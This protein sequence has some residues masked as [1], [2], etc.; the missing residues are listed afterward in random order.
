MQIVKNVLMAAATLAVSYGAHAQTA[1]EIVAK[2]V[3]AIGGKE[4]IKG[5]NSLVMQTSLEVM[6]NEASGTST[7]VPGKGFRTDAEIMGSKMVQVVTDKGGWAINPMA[8][9]KAEALPAEAYNAAKDQLDIADPLVDYAAK[10]HKLE[11][12]GREKVGAVDAYK[13][14]LTSKDNVTTT[15]LVDPST[16]YI[17]QSIKSMEMMGQSMDLVITFGDYKK[18]DYG[19]VMPYTLTTDFGGQFQLT[20][21]VTNVEV[22]KP[23]DMKIFEMPK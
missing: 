9:G 15:Y 11:L 2:H 21:K 22:N 23:V 18:N 6:G 20:T 13:L 8:G 10:G 3:V 5:I 17:L 12:Q 7:L 1:D 14:K 19:L 4:K 16:F